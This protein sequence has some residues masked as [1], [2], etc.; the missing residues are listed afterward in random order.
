[1]VRAIPVVLGLVV[2]IAVQAG[3]AEEAVQRDQE[4]MTGSWRVTQAEIAGAPVP[5]AEYRGLRLT[6]A[7]GKFTAR[8]GD[9]EAQEGTYTID[10]RKSP[11]HIAITRSN[12]P[13]GSRKQLG[14]YQFTGDTLRICTFDNGEDRPSSFETRNR[15]G[16]T[17]LVLRREPKS[18]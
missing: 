3:P 4:R 18:P 17:L 9:E 7:D 16:S 15:P 14:I 10:P 11:R 6:F 12:G 2:V 1:M 5:P 8:R 13:A